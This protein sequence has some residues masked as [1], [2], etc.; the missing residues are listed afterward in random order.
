MR[1]DSMSDSDSA[2]L[3]AAVDGY[4]KV[5][6]DF[7]TKLYQSAGAQGPQDAGPGFGGQ[8][9]APGGDDFVDGDY[10]EK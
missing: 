9:Q 4:T 6:N 10:T 2:T 8:G 3:K 7:S 1:A 5:L